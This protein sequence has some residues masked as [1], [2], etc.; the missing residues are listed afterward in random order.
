VR[1]T[2]LSI[3]IPTHVLRVEA[4]GGGAEGVG[5][6]AANQSLHPNPKHL[7]RVGVAIPI[8]PLGSFN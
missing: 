4:G 5:A 3:Q 6:G 7:L 1:R 8:P 2:N